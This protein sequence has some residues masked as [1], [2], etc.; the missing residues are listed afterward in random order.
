M[1]LPNIQHKTTV[2]GW[3]PG[4]LR[5]CGLCTPP[6]NP[7]LIPVVP[8]TRRGDYRAPQITTRLADRQTLISLCDNHTRRDRRGADTDPVEPAIGDAVMFS[9][10]A[11][12]MAAGIVETTGYAGTR[13]AFIH[14]ADLVRA[15]Q[16]GHAVDVRRAR[17]SAF[18]ALPEESP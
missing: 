15:R 11:R 1:T 7:T 14:P 3:H 8:A 9:Y 4:R 6:P 18:F 10:S 5:Y 13:V 12:V 2:G 16:N 17:P